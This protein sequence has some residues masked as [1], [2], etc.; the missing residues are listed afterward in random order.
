[1]LGILSR[2][3]ALFSIQIL[4]IAD[5]N[6]EGRIFCDHMRKKMGLIL[7]ELTRFERE[8][9]LKFVKGMPMVDR[10]YHLIYDDA[11]RFKEN[12]CHL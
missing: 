2:L 8:N 4:H 9:A 12:S 11:S 7:E 1:M 10:K 5:V 6:G 3:Q